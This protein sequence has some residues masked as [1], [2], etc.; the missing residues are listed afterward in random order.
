MST[1]KQPVVWCSDPNSLNQKPTAFALHGIQLEGNITEQHV[2]AL[3]EIINAAAEGRLLLPSDGA[4]V[5]LDCGIGIASMIV[6]NG[7]ECIERQSPVCDAIAERLSPAAGDDHD[8]HSKSMVSPLATPPST[9]PTIIVSDCDTEATASAK[10][11]PK[12]SEFE[13]PALSKYDYIYEFLCCAKC[14]NDESSR[15]SHVDCKRVAES[16]AAHNQTVNAMQPSSRQ[17]DQTATATDR[18]A[19]AVDG[20][21][22]CENKVINHSAFD[23]RRRRRHSK[24]HATNCQTKLE[25]NGFLPIYATIKQKMQQHGM[26]RSAQT[27][28]SDDHNVVESSELSVIDEAVVGRSFAVTAD[29]HSVPSATTTVVTAVAD[30]ESPSAADAS[31]DMTIRV[32]SS[33][34]SSRKTSVDSSCTVGSMDSGFIEMQNKQIEASTA[35]NGEHS[36]EDKSPNELDA[37]TESENAS[38]KECSTQSSRNRRKSYEEFKAIFH[39][40]NTSAEPDLP[41]VQENEL[42]LPI[43]GQRQKDKIK[44]RRKSYEEFKALVREHY[45]GDATRFKRKNSKRLSGSKQKASKES[46]KAMK[47]CVVEE[48]MVEESAASQAIV[49]SNQSTVASKDI[50]DEIYKKNCK[51]YDKLISYGTI[52]DIM[53]KKTDIYYKVYRKY[54]AYMTYGTI[55]EILQRKSDDYEIFRRSRAASEKFTNKRVSIG[56]TKFLN[57][58]VD[59]G[60]RPPNFGTI[61]DIVQRKQSIAAKKS[62]SLPNGI[63][64]AIEMAKLADAEKRRKAKSALNKCGKI[65]DIIQTESTDTDAMASNGEN[66]LNV[67]NRFLV[68]KVNEADLT[69]SDTGKTDDNKTHTYSEPASFLTKFTGGAPKKA[70][71]ANRMRR[72]SHI[73]SYTHR[74]HQSSDNSAKSQSTAIESMPSAIEEVDCPSEM[75]TSPTNEPNDRCGCDDD[76]HPPAINRTKC[77]KLSSAIAIGVEQPPKIAPRKQSIAPPPIP[78]S[79]SSQA[80]KH[81]TITASNDIMVAPTTTTTATPTIPIEMDS[82]ASTMTHCQ[83]QAAES[84]TPSSHNCLHNNCCSNNN[85]NNDNPS[86]MNSGSA[87]GGHKLNNCD[88]ILITTT[89]TSTTSTTTTT[90]AAAAAAPATTSSHASPT[91]PLD[92]APHKKTK[93]RRL[94]EFTR[95]EFLNEKS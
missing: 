90:I 77:R 65:Y 19:L 45:D 79:F 72:F 9:P 49:P 59:G 6:N 29:I 54:D 24:P 67:I 66:N 26:L 80:N 25:R 41:F 10:F 36:V 70:K 22:S 3:R 7:D 37:V 91:L 58:D 2:L 82:V 68:K 76:T 15:H 88:K 81:S 28:T 62:Q 47:E 48:P 5:L 57:D 17:P 60:E 32:P 39:N 78:P 71:K 23:V 40:R 64:G 75:K 38:L 42:S 69:V 14:M 20:D 51:I 56:D 87:N 46:T 1:I 73:L 11:E 13:T 83:Q 63:I 12:Y 18:T 34:N 43:F 50:K 95:G 31:N 94:S 92:R 30:E 93:S 27:A 55:Y 4:I 61:Y 33:T 16:M 44:A 52:Y 84:V 89:S 85:N 74:S 35:T 8:I 86:H 53:Q 21:E